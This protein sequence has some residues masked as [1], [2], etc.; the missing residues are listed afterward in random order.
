MFELS[1][2]AGSIR[3][4]INYTRQLFVFLHTPLLLLYFRF[5]SPH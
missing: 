2:S 4:I 3:N 1:P 5:P